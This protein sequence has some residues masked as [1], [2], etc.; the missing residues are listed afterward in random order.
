MNRGE[1]LNRVS[2]LGY[3]LF[4]SEETFDAN[5]T[6]AEVIKNKEL[7]FWEGFPILLANSCQ[8]GLFNYDGVKSHLKKSL[9]KSAL[10]SLLLV[11]F[12]L[13][14]A[15]NIK[16]TWLEALKKT[17]NL[18]HKDLNKIYQDFSK[19]GKIKVLD[20]S[21]SSER[22]KSTFMRYFKHQ[23]SKL[24]E[25]SL[26][27]EEYGLEYA[28]SQLFSPKQKELF[29]RKLKGEKMSKTEREYYS[30]RVKKKIM[31]LANAE[32]HKLAQKVQGVL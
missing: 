24:K 1:L 10:D 29:L 31:A 7:R 5:A 2:K 9:D 20:K 18:K 12:A 6:L 11:S 26:L 16:F 25:F 27:Q 19:K 13:Y 28:L 15:L 17:L 30:R 14:K 21:L 32:L 3:P 4:E 23:E 8:K 22:L